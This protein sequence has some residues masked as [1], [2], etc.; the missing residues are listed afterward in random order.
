MKY[1]EEVEKHLAKKIV[2]T[3][4]VTAKLNKQS[5]ENDFEN[6][7]NLLDS[8]R[9]P[10]QY[11]WM[12]DIRI[13]EFTAHVLTQSS[14]D[15]NQYFKT[16][17]FVEVYLEDESDEAKAVANAAK[18]CL[19]RTLNQRELYHYQKYVRG[20]VINQL[21]GHVYARCWW[22]KKTYK[23]F[24]GYKPQI[25]ETGEDLLGPTYE[26]IQEPQYQDQTLY[27][28]FNYD[29]ID[30]RNI[31]MDDTYVYS[32]NDKK[33]IIILSESSV[34]ELR[35]NEEEFGYFNLDKLGLI[36]PPKE[37]ET[38]KNTYNK[39]LGSH[40]AEEKVKPTENAC[41]MYDIVE[42]YGKFLCKVTGRN[43]W[44]YPEKV[45]PGYDKYGKPLPGAEFVETI[46]T[47]AISGTEK[48][49]IRFQ[50]TPYVDYRG[51]PYKPIIRGL[52]Y[53]HP[54]ADGGM[55]DGR[56][57][58]EL[59]YALDDSVCVGMD[60]VMLAT[61]PVLKVKRYEAEDNS[62]IYIE[63]QHNIPLENPREDLEELKIDDNIDGTIGLAALFTDKMR[64][65]D[66][67]YPPTMGSTPALASTTATATAG[68]ESHVDLRSNYKSLT[69]ENTFLSALYNMILQMTWSFAE[70]ETAE[71][72][73]GAKIDDFDPSK[74]YFF[75]PVSQAVESEYSKINKVKMWT[76][77]LG[78]IVNLRHPDTV[79]LVNHIMKNIFVYMGDE[80]V[81]FA[82]SMLDETK[83]IE[84]KGGSA[85]GSPTGASNQYGIQQS[86]T[87]TTI[88]G[89]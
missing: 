23:D 26:E 74:D 28:R 30:P 69:F 46:I 58:K 43:D 18:E 54:T 48:V 62:E 86:P 40:Q 75:K 83:P 27:D 51:I 39:S 8:I 13:P 4:M 41:A 70:K 17:D 31:L 89:Q 20:R 12:A 45:E 60:R 49:L 22:E 63:P 71:K 78:Y 53:I 3:E 44:G 21:L 67:I 19:N 61:L 33:F 77:V 6:Y 36:E 50:S 79:K 34:E 10:K 88:R 57:S 11:E 65:A 2:D 37:T 32:L 25:K 87:E 59:Q 84:G 73:L 42:R 47:F 7:V 1:N 14:L 80:F 81:N 85:E 5:E 68:A 35:A 29:I 16:R 52:C 38:S 64:Q 9:E 82:N 55:G 56:Q 24:T 72:L 66:N 15:V 76:Q